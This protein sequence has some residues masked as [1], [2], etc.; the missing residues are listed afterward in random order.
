MIIKT[1]NSA[2]MICEDCVVPTDNKI[3]DDLMCVTCP[4]CKQ[5]VNA[6]ITLEL[7]ICPK[8]KAEVTR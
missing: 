4:F 5:T 7:I 1:E 3:S 2:K 6:I 8:C